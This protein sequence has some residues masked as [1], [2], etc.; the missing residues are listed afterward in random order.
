MHTNCRLI[1][2]LRRLAQIF[3]GLQDFPVLQSSSVILKD[4]LPGVN[5]RYLKEKCL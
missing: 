3:L 1:A 4:F 5:L 2:A